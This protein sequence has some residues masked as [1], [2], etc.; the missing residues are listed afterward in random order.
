MYGASHSF[1]GEEFYALKSITWFSGPMIRKSETGARAHWTCTL[2]TN[3]KVQEHT[4]EQM[5]AQCYRI[6]RKPIAA[7]AQT[8]Q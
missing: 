3:E 5:S 1:Y 4:Q 2:A 8:T 7:S 6:A